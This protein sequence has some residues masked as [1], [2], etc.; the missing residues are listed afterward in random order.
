MPKVSVIVTTYNR[1]EFLSETILSILNQT[2]QDF[3]LIVVDNFSNYDFNSLMV[4]FNNPKILHYQNQNNGVIAK[5]R[6]FGIKR[7]KGE[8]IAFCDDDDIWLNT[9]LET[10]ICVF[11]NYPDVILISTMAKAFGI[12]C[13]FPGENYGI[14]N[15]RH[16]FLNKCIYYSNPI[17]LSSVLV[18]K[19]VLLSVNGFSENHSLVA[20]E[21]FDLWIRLASKGDFLLIKE[22][23]VYYR[24][25][26]SNISITNPNTIIPSSY[27]SKQDKISF[28][29]LNVKK[30]TNY[31]SILIYSIIQLLSLF[32]FNFRTKF[33]LYIKKNRSNSFRYNL[34][35]HNLSK[36]Q[37]LKYEK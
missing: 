23:L 27:W 6:N 36:G 18:K 34:L 31:T 24:I 29:K 12:N 28:C 3:E 10:Q 30:K 13:N 8:F 20:V 7:A 1:K 5:N 21:D 9:K 14:I 19:D 11:Q 32:Y 37:Y 35:N 22:I 17:I 33:R 2:Y 26:T 4:G 15:L 25:Q 16:A